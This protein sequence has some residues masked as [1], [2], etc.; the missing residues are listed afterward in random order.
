MKIFPDWR[1][2]GRAMRWARKQDD[3]RRS[4]IRDD[5]T[6]RLVEIAWDRAAYTDLVAHTWTPDGGP[7][8]YVNLQDGRHVEAEELDA[9]TTLRFLAHLDLIP[10]ELAEPSKRYG[11]CVEC[12]RVAEWVEPTAQFAGRWCHL[13]PERPY[14]VPEVQAEAQATGSESDAWELLDEAMGPVLRQALAT[15]PT[16]CRC[17]WLGIGTPEHERSGLCLP[18]V[19]A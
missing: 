7:H 2:V 15:S 4:A 18:V 3:V 6:G 11:R 16:L 13:R 17:P 19:S 14:H 8:L 9:L 5:Q 1:A 10:V 12:G